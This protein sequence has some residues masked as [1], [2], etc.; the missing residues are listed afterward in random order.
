MGHSESWGCGLFDHLAGICS[1]SLWFPCLNSTLAASK[2]SSTLHHRGCCSLGS[3]AMDLQRQSIH[4]RTASRRP[5]GQQVESCYSRRSSES[6]CWC[7][8]CCTS[9]TTRP[10]GASILWLELSWSPLCITSLLF[11]MWS[12]Q[13]SGVPFLNLFYSYHICIVLL[14]LLIGYIK[15]FVVISSRTQ[16]W[17]LLKWRNFWCDF[18]PN[19]ELGRVHRE[20]LRPKR[21]SLH[22]TRTDCLFVFLKVLINKSWVFAKKF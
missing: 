10:H 5:Q 6:L 19:A 18:G 14:S 15:D 17:S 3:D 12:V 1:A 16:A 2:H 20:V 8:I 4:H 21:F 9:S 13:S 11:P 7:G 22:Q